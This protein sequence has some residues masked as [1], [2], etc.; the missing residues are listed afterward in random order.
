MLGLSNEAPSAKY[1]LATFI[2]LFLVDLAMSLP[3]GK[4][5]DLVQ[6]YD[7]VLDSFAATAV[8]YLANL[9]I[10]YKHKT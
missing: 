6:A 3:R 4:I 5:P 1:T 10:A 9:G 7:A 8:I 2:I